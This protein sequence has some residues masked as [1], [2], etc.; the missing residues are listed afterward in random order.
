MASPVN[1]RVAIGVDRRFQLDIHV[2]GG[3]AEVAAVQQPDLGHV[4]DAALG[5][6]RILVEI[7]KI[8]SLAHEHLEAVG[9]DL[10]DFSV[11]KHRKRG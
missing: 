8:L 5:E 10:G 1:Q 6:P 2:E 9:G 4:G 3:Q 11:H 7:Q